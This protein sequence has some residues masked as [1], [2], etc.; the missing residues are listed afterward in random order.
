MN[1]EAIFSDGTREYIEPW[2]PNPGDKLKIRIRTERLD[3][4]EVYLC[5]KK[6]RIRVY[7][8]MTRGGFDYYRTTVNLTDEPFSYYFEIRDQNGVCYLDRYGIS[9]EVR[10]QYMFT[11]VPGFSVP[12]WAKGAVMYQI[13]VDRFCNGDKM[14]DVASGEYYYISQRARRVLD[15]NTPPSEFDVGNFYGGDLEGVRQKLYYLKSLGVEVIY[16]NPLFVSPSN[17]KYDIQDYDYIDPHFGKIVYDGGE[18]LKTGDHNNKNATKYI[19]RVTD[20]RNLEASNEFF[21][22]FVEEAHEKG[23]KVILDGVFNH[24]G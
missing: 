11:V 9:D 1:R 4:V 5:T 7:F 10:L 3:Q 24:C 23:I 17:H 15:W 19:R 18:T 16:F 8:E 21:A 20:K 13:L 14:N 2:E 6:T 22:K 12:D